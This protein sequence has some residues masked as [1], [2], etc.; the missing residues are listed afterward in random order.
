LIY[1]CIVKEDELILDRP[2]PLKMQET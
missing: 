2:I 1:D